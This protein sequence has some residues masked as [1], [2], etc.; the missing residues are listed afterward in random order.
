MQC[1]DVDRLLSAGRRVSDLMLNQQFKTHLEACR[2]C[3]GLVAWAETPCPVPEFSGE[4]EERIRSAILEDLTPV[5]PLPSMWAS[6]A[7]VFAF[8]TA[9]AALYAAR[10]GGAGLGYLTTKE[11]LFLGGLSMAVIGL[12]TAAL[13]SSICPGSRRRFPLVLPVFLLAAGFPLFSAVFFSAGPEDHSAFRGI[14]CLTGGLL[15]SVLTGAAA[16]RLARR[17]YSDDWALSGALIGTLAGAVSLVALQVSCPV[18]ELRHLLLWHGATLFLA[19]SGGYL[20]GRAR[21]RI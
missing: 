8:T 17:G 5:R 12:A 9:V 4:V 6:I 13:W 2:R 21:R 18:H 11:L 1:Q 14:R 19:I 15:A 16:Y 7:F 20:A 10:T 3:S